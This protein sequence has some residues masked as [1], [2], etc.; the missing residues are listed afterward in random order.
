M[1]CE[2]QVKDKD[3]IEWEW[4]IA[5]FSSRKVNVSVIK[6]KDLYVLSSNTPEYFQRNSF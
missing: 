4:K 3:M 6:K 2:R 1:M 5:K